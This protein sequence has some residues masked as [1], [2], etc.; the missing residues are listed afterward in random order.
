MDMTFIEFIKAVLVLVWIVIGFIIFYEDIMMV[1]VKESETQPSSSHHTETVRTVEKIVYVNGNDNQNQDSNN[2]SK[3][4]GGLLFWLRSFRKDPAEK[5]KALEEKQKLQQ[6]KAQQK[7]KQDALKLQAQQ[8]KQALLDQQKLE[9]QKQQEKQQD[10][11]S[12]TLSYEADEVEDEKSFEDVVFF[13]GNIQVKKDFY[14]SLSSPLQK[15]FKSYF[16]DDADTHLVKELQYEVGKDNTAFFQKVFNYI[17]TYRHVIS[18]ELL[19]VLQNE[20]LRL[21]NKNSDTETLLYEAATRVSYF[22]RKDKKH[23]A[24]AETWATSDVAL[25]RKVFNPKKRYVYSYVRLAIILEKQGRIDEAITLVE[26][27]LSRDLDDKTK[28][29]YSERLVRLKGLKKPSQASPAKPLK[30]ATLKVVPMPT[31]VESDEQMDQL[32][33]NAMEDVQLFKSVPKSR[34]EFYD[35]LTDLEKKEFKSYFIDEGDQHLVKGLQ[36][37]INGSNDQFFYR[38]FNYIYEYRKTISASLL[39]KIYNELILYAG[40]DDTSKSLISEAA[41]R[42]LYYNRAKK[43]YLETSIPILESDIKRQNSVFNVKKQYVYSYLRYA[44]ILEKQ[45]R[46]EE[47]IALVEDALSRELDDRTKGN[48]KERLVRLKGMLKPVEKEE[49]EEEDVAD[50]A[51]L[52]NIQIFKNVIEERKGFYESLT[53]DEQSEFRRYFVDKHEEHLA[54]ELQYVI[55]KNN[56]DFFMRVFNYIYRY[57]RIISYGLLVKLSDELQ[58]FS[59]GDPQTQT[60]LYEAAIRVAYFRRKGVQFLDISQVWSENDVKIHRTILNSKDTYVYSFTRL[61]IILEKKKAFKEALELVEDALKRQ[62]NDKTRTGY[63]GRKVRLIKKLGA[64]S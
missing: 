49:P 8:E 50:E 59:N 4:K 52:E 51:D 31:V 55:G 11:K 17:Y 5:Q 41:V 25:Q 1:D 62:L 63:Q 15:E 36:Y 18:P 7:E 37:T 35:T 23:L 30:E 29:N 3:S 39:D 20:L 60:L 47:A 54:P 21:G 24:L 19:E 61:A 12:T 9:Q 45:G 32:D 48:Y 2:Q 33:V 42:T 56:G 57:R 53:P 22:R 16:M 13:K 58:S 27:A 10:Q 26:D 44:I 40:S 14:E 38:V 64:A 46:I 28:G 34:S 6:E 43:G